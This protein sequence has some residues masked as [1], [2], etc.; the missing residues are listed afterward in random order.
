MDFCNQSS[1]HRK[2]GK[3]FSEKVHPKYW[4]VKWN[5]LCFISAISNMLHNKCTKNWNLQYYIVGTAI[6]RTK[7]SSWDKTQ[8]EC[9]YFNL[10]FSR[11]YNTANVRLKCM[12]SVSVLSQ[13][14]VSVLFLQSLLTLKISYTC[15]CILILVMQL[16][17]YAHNRKH[18]DFILHG[19]DNSMAMIWW[20]D[21]I[22]CDLII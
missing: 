3:F 14:L 21:Y 5:P 12:H 2:H 17:S 18:A 1:C 7:T 4:Y 15:L 6:K 9:M 10:Y 8:T 20:L 19:Q 22:K 16:Y 13:L 11:V